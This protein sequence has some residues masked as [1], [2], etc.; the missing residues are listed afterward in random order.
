[1]LRVQG[2]RNRAVWKVREVAL[3]GVGLVGLVSC[4]ASPSPCRAA[5]RAEY[6]RQWLDSDQKLQANVSVSEEVFHGRLALIES[7]LFHGLSDE[8]QHL[9]LQSTGCLGVLLQNYASAH[10]LLVRS[11][12]MAS[13]G[14]GDWGCRLLAA[15][16]MADMDDAT[17]ALAHVAH[18]W[19]DQL[20]HLPAR[21]VMRIASR[22]PDSDRQ[23][24]ARLELRLA[25]FHASFRGEDG[26]PLSELWSKLAMELFE[27]GRKAE[28]FEVIAS[29]DSP[30]E[31]LAMR[32][33]R[34][35]DDVVRQA[36]R[37][38]DVGA[39]AVREIKDHE[40]AVQRFPR[41]IDAVV[42]LCHAYLDAGRYRE[43]QQVADTALSRLE[44]YDEDL[45]AINW[46]RDIYARAAVAT[47]SWDAAAN[48][49]ELAAQG[50]EGG[51]P[52]VSHVINLGAFYADLG[53]ADKALEVLAR[54][55][56]PDQDESMSPYGR[57]QWHGARLAAALAKADAALADAELRYLRT[58]QTDAIDAYQE[59]L[60]R[61]GR[62]DEA[63]QLLIARLHDPKR[64]GVALSEIQIYDYPPALPGIA[65]LRARRREVVDRKDVQQAIAQV[66]RIETFPIPPDLD[67]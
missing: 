45:S 66:G 7:P 57:M 17:L 63:A 23:R 47:R 58:H 1:M 26:I 33:D 30:R 28:A 37:L 67:Y 5:T 46:L 55:P 40:Q 36:P 39:A 50:M 15:F 14:V 60:F 24:S 4:L 52:Y 32:I 48:A 19:P 27:R 8:L 3:V 18:S 53:R 9:R 59:G 10:A 49:L 31:I 20:S 13:Q 12:G 2:S 61:T 11:S 6:L 44:A 16:G 41:K 54:I 51:K 62:M 43:A 25:L 34:R 65:Q 21:I 38:F 22:D 56:E 42:A 35:L 64:Y 29:V